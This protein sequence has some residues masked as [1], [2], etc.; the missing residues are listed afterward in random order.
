MAEDKKNTP[1]AEAVAG[2]NTGKG[3]T[4][5]VDSKN[6]PSTDVK[7]TK[8]EDAEEVNPFEIEEEAYKRLAAIFKQKPLCEKL[9]VTTDYSIFA[10][11]GFAKLHAKTLEEKEIHVAVRG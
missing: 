11:K 10:D 2:A 8:V 7:N 1:A 3:N 9:F 4:P 6:E 5:P